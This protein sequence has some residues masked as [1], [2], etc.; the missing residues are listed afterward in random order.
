MM[1]RNTLSKTQPDSASYTQISICL[2]FF[3]E[4][5]GKGLEHANIAIKG[6][7]ICYCPKK[8]NLP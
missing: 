1:S 4:D 8:D 7:K 5:D 2:Y 6:D 3:N